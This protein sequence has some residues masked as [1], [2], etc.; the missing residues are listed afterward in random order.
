M[1]I[2]LV[3]VLPTLSGPVLTSQYIL[4]AAALAAS[5]IGPIVAAVN[6]TFPHQTVELAAAAVPNPFVGVAPKTYIDSNQTILAL[7]D[8][9]NNGEASP[10]QPLLVKSRGVDVIFVMD[11]VSCHELDLVQLC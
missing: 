9:G 6:A 1:S 2:T 10:L 5:P 11:A 8:G 7:V 3:Y 4:Q